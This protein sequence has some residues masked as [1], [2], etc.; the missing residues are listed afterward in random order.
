MDKLIFTNI[1]KTLK[2]PLNKWLL[3]LNSILFLLKFYYNYSIKVIMAIRR[4]N[5]MKNI[6]KLI[7]KYMS[8]NEIFEYSKKLNQKYYAYMLD[9]QVWKLLF[10]ISPQF[11]VDE[12]KKIQ[13]FTIGHNV[14]NH[15]L[16]TF[17][18]CE[19]Q[20]KYFLTKTFIKRNKDT[21]I[22]EMRVNS[23]RIDVG[24]INGD[25]HA[26]EI[27]TE[28]DTITK[29]E[30]QV[31]DY[32]RVFE[33]VEVVAHPKHIKSIIKIIPTNCGVI[34][35]EIN[36]KK[37][38]LNVERE[39]LRSEMLDVNAQIKALTSKDLEF[40]IKSY[41]SISIPLKRCDREEII[42]SLFDSESINELF[43][44]AI[45]KRY[46]DRS[47]Y[48]CKYFNKINPIDIQELY[49]GP[50]HPQKIYVKNSSIVTK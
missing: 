49:I 20:L 16:M 43:K 18:P 33:F 24:R 25:S 22:F 34:S 35:Y 37:C 5:T 9:T 2:K 7:N 19:K 28:L 6:T 44:I 29:L 26:Y 13:D 47:K 10:E 36:K 31:N 12:F 32:L 30:K 23:S 1:I 17:Y 39:A 21:T 11:L 50:I 38:N 15:I 40:I 45:K 14:V 42:L 27:K 48:L 41:L 8:V 46:E 3:L 4:A